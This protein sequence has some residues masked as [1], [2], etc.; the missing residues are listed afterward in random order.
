VFLIGAVTG[1]LGRVRRLQRRQQIGYS[2][3]AVPYHSYESL[4]QSLCLQIVR[5]LANLAAQGDC[6]TS[7]N[8]AIA[9]VPGCL[10]AL[11][12][13]TK[14]DSAVLQIEAATALWNLAFD[15]GVREMIAAEG[16]VHS[17][18][19]I[20]KQCCGG[21]VYSLQ[22]RVT[23][24]LWGLSASQGNSVLIGEEGGIPP[25]IQ[26]ARSV[27]EV[28]CGYGY[29]YGYIHGYGHRVGGLSQAWEGKGGGGGEDLPAVT[30]GALGLESESR[31]GS[32]LGDWDRRG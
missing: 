19:G 11:V 26:L 1:E 23:G 25:L 9:R 6:N 13:L 4:N 31:M 14:G 3:S 2:L 20:A 8:V 5:V 7:N 22:E 32:W 24:A 30:S 29:G 15:E 28:S 10:S 12:S 18:V 16:G 21:A 27:S 17:L